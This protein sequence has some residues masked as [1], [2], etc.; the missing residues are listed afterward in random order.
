MRGVI[1]GRGY[2]VGGVMLWMELWYKRGYYMG[3]VMGMRGILNK[4]EL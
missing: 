2:D 4:R 1:D 3:W